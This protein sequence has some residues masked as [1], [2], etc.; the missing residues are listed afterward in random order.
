MAQKTMGC[1]LLAVVLLVPALL[2]QKAAPD[3]SGRWMLAGS[4]RAWDALKTA[5]THLIISQSGEEIRLDR[6]SGEKL[7][8]SETFVADGKERKRYATRTTT[9]YTK[10]QWVKGGFVITTRT[11]LDPQ[12]TQ[13]YAETD[14][15]FLI[16][17]GLKLQNKLSDG[18]MLLYSKQPAAP[19]DTPGSTSE[20]R[21]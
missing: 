11:V 9:A 7:L 6:Y 16:D 21:K 8:S 20:K 18:T 12:G 2:A 10:A 14:K 17:G 1:I 19:A 3:L 4:N 13:S 5:E 15:W